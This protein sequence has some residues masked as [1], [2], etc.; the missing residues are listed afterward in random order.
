MIVI[1]PQ[2]SNEAETC[3]RCDRLKRDTVIR[4]G[5]FHFALLNE[6][7]DADAPP[8]AILCTPCRRFVAEA[9]NHGG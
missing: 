5:E 1:L 2:L 6:D 3:T 8:R 4:A 7:G 9:S